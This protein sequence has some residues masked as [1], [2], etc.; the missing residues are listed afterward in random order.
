MLSFI[1]LLT[2]NDYSA[3]RCNLHDRNIEKKSFSRSQMQR[4]KLSTDPQDLDCLNEDLGIHQWYLILQIDWI[5]IMDYVGESYGID[6]L[7]KGLETYS[8]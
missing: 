8:W 7:N 2:F 5:K 3:A 6:W 4:I 1:N